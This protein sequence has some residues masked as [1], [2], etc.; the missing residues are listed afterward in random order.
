[1]FCMSYMASVPSLLFR[2][3][4]GPSLNLSYKKNFLG[5]NFLKL[6]KVSIGRMAPA[7]LILCL[8]FPV[9]SC[10]VMK[11]VA[12]HPGTFK[13]FLDD[14]YLEFLVTKT[15][16]LDKQLGQ[17]WLTTDV[18]DRVAVI[19]GTVLSQ[20]EKERADEVV[21]DVEGLRQVI[22]NVFVSKDQKKPQWD[23]LGLEARIRLALI[24]DRD[25][26]SLPIEVYS[27]MYRVY[28]TGIVATRKEEARIIT[29]AEEKGAWKVKSFIVV[30]SKNS[31][32][33]K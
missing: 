26:K 30:K 2:Y 24:R 15:L 12:D 14:T 16:R 8:V 11:R 7:I 29:L 31:S 19:N 32:T 13:E 1:M 20:E 3:G 22:N 21:A 10:Y 5:S 18:N 25:I 28:L 23:D 4:L 9:F 27:N 33:A 17:R 6:L